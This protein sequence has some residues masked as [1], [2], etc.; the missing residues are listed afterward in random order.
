[1]IFYP[2]IQLRSFTRE[3]RPFAR[4]WSASG[5]CFPDIRAGPARRRQA[6]AENWSPPANWR[7]GCHHRSAVQFETRQGSSA[8]RCSCPRN[9]GL[10]FC[11]WP[12]VLCRER[13]GK[14]STQH[15]EPSSCS[16]RGDGRGYLQ[17]HRLFVPVVG[18]VGAVI[19]WAYQS[20]S[21]RLG[22]IDLFACEIST[23]CRVATVSSIRRA[24]MLASSTNRP[25][26]LP[27]PLALTSRRTISLP[28]KTIFRCLRATHA[29]CRR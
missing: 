12:P 14:P 1:M 5:Q 27:I 4:V 29:T 13:A 6:F 8:D 22:V 7:S 28:K 3:H 16:T 18:V 15:G 20:G 2:K 25:H 21:A 19:A 9:I 17:V 23:L 11:L 10:S 26:R 24:D